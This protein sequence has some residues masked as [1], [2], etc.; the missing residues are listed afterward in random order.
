M[1]T[2]HAPAQP[3]LD[4]P[5]EE[6]LVGRARAMRE[7]L[8]ARQEEA[9][10]LTHL[11]PDLHEQFLAH[12]FYDMF[13]PKTYGGLEVSPR[14]FFEV[15]KELARGDMGSAWCFALAANHALHVASW[16][17]KEVQDRAFGNRDFRAASVSAPTV[18][19]RRTD[20]G[21]VLDGVVDYCSGI[22]HSTWY[23]GQC[24][25]EQEEGAAPVMGMFLAPQDTFERMHNWG[26]ST[27]L[28]ATG[29]ESIRFTDAFVAAD[30]VIEDANMIDI[31]VKDGT[32]GS[33][34]HGNPMYAGRGLLTFTVSL[35]SLAVGG[36]YHALDEFE[37]LMRTRKTPLPPVQLRLHDV[38][39]QRHYGAAWTKIRTAE[40]ALDGV[41]AQHAEYCRGTVD[42]TREYTFLDDWSL[43]CVVREII[44]QLWETLQH[45]LLRVVGSGSMRRGERFERIFRDMSSLLTH[46]NPMLREQAFRNTANLL[47]EIPPP[48][49]R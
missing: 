10:K 42:G 3:G 17:P 39:Y 12:G 20:G 27:G 35:A 19:A 44:V 49:A 40:L 28:K 36:L 22:P 31:P 13:V 14:T 29:S 34:L 6:E 1:T 21:Y 30:L 8:L 5:S 18:R 48:E 37:H 4:A 25:V 32:V 41:I 38:D 2:V 9:E 11:P 23:L 47:L 15:C 24:M 45:D 16:Y 46:R 33:R 7:E 26:E 43:S